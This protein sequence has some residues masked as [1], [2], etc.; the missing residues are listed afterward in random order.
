MN[1]VKRKEKLMIFLEYEDARRLQRERLERS[2]Y[3]FQVLA[4]LA[5]DHGSVATADAKVVELPHV[6]A[7]EFTEQIGA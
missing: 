4:A 1:P 6:E 2:V 5:T 7:C 3:R